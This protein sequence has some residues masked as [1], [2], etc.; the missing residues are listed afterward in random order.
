MLD[1]VDFLTSKD[2]MVLY[3]A[4]EWPKIKNSRIVVVGIAN[5][6]DLPV[7]LLPWL[8]QAGCMPQVVS[9]PP[10]NASSLQKIAEQRVHNLDSSALTTVAI[11]LAAKKVAAGSGDARLMLDVCREAQN[12][13]KR[14]KQDKSCVQVVSSILS[15]RGG[16]SAAVDTIRQLPVQQQLALCVAANAVFFS[17]RTTSASGKMQKKATIG[18]LYDS[19]VRMCQRAHVSILSFP[20]FADVCSN[21]LTHHGLVDIPLTGRGKSAKTLRSR[22]IRLRVPIEDVRAGIADKGFLPMLLVK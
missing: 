5:S 3:S 7:R 16:L 19:F 10:Y 15:Q 18:G 14:N 2:Q 17:S 12:E 22:A 20:E 9:F 13:M 11:S 4:F 8:R 1:E 6:I 21:A